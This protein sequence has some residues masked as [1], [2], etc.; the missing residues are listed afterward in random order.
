MTAAPVTTAAVR[1]R[2]RWIDL[3]GALALVRVVTSHAF[4]WAWLPLVC[5]PMGVLFALAGRLV[6]SSLDRAS[7]P[8]PFYRTGIRRLLP[9][10]WAF[11]LVVVPLMLAM[12]WTVDPELGSA[13]FTGSTAWTWIFPLLDPPGS[14]A[15]YTWVSPL[16]YLRTCLWLVLLSPG[17]LW[18]FRR[19]P[20]RVAAVPVVITGL[21]VSGLLNLDDPASYDVL[22]ELGV[23]TC[24][25]L[26]GFA[27]RDGLLQ[28]LDGRRVVA[29]GGA[30]MGLGLWYAFANRAAFGSY[31]LDDIPLADMLYSL[32]AV[33]VL[34][35]FHPTLSWLR[36]VPTLDA[37]LGL[38]TSRAMTVYLWNG[39][40][41][42]LAPVLLT[43]TGLA[44]DVPPD[45]RGQAI[46]YGVGW[47]LVCVAV[48]LFGWIEDVAAARRPKLLGWTRVPRAGSTASVPGT[49]AVSVGFEGN[50]VLAGPGDGST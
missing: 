42:W 23:F 25:W 7:G 20:R 34:L 9:P 50:T 24:C 43:R 22:I 32:G 38:V 14:T 37:V 39:F 30:L 18:L 5:P 40:A 11:G 8:A 35:R 21:L 17:L 13:P 19:W 27:H 10:L 31:N 1:D 26:A 36:R 29:F 41:L 48:L 28:R 2:D 15:G 33:L 49:S 4:T 6:A 45:L 12:H 44:A 46:V 47:L 16:W 3:L